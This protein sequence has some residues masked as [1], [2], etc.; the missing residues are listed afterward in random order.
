MYTDDAPAR[1]T[2]AHLE[3]Y[4][5]M[6]RDWQKYQLN[7]IVRIKLMLTDGIKLDYLINSCVVLLGV[8]EVPGI[9]WDYCNEPY[10]TSCIYKERY[11]LHSNGQ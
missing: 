2:R 9:V 5:S 3:C 8:P 11:W 7:V 1:S 6:G 4:V 10:H